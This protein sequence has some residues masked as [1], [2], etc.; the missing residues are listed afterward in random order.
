MIFH[1]RM[2]VYLVLSDQTRVSQLLS[3]SIPWMS[4]PWCITETEHYPPNQTSPNHQHPLQ[5]GNQNPLFQ[6]EHSPL[7]Q[8]DHKVR[9]FLHPHLALQPKGIL[10]LLH[11]VLLSHK[12]NDLALLHGFEGWLLNVEIVQIDGQFHKCWKGKTGETVR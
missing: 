10:S 12:C 11:P 1:L 6:A 8:E 7:L 9:N 3:S 5:N 2:F 4:P